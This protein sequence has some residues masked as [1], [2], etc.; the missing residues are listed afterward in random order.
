[1]PFVQGHGARRPTPREVTDLPRV[2]VWLKL[3]R[4]W[5]GLDA[6]LIPAIFFNKRSVQMIC[7]GFLRTLKPVPNLPLNF[8]T[9]GYNR[10]SR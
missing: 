6:T 2:T 9:S 4:D 1:M 5:Q 10:T 8:G 7:R 3:V